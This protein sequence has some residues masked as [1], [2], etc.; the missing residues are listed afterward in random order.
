[1]RR[2]AKQLG[3]EAMSLYNH[4]SN[5]DDILAGISNLVAA[6]IELP[7]SSG[8]WK[9]AMRRSAMSTRDV[10][11]AHPWASGLWM[12]RRGGGSAQLRRT[13]WILKTFREAGLPAELTYHA[14]HIL[15]AYLLGITVQSE[16]FPYRGAELA[17]VASR[18]LDRIPADEYPDLVEHVK[19]HL[20]PPQGAKSGFDLGLDL[21]LEGLEREL[22]AGGGVSAGTS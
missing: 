15:E 8:D 12:S 11:Q 20:D 6:E 14:L 9:D 7:A 1:M 21:I 10:L 5:K 18:F 22:T 3:V 2:L 13:D 4:V 17:G 16:R 19:Q